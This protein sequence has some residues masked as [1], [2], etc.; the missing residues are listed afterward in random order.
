MNPTTLKQEVKKYWNQAA[1]GTEFID[2]KKYSREYFKAIEAFRY[3]IEPEIFA[4]A[5][6][7]RF[8]GKKVLEVGVGAG[9]DFVQW[10]RAGAIAYG[11]DLTE[12]A[13]NHVNHRLTINNLKAAEVTIGDAENLPY[14]N[15]SFDLVYS[16]GVIHH[17]PD[18]FKSLEELVRVT[19]PGGTIKLMIYNRSSLYAFYQYLRHALLRGKPF[20]SFRNVLYYHQESLGTQ[21]FTFKEAQKMIAQLPVTVNLMQAPITNHDL[22]YQKSK[23]F[24]WIAYICACLGG[25]KKRGWFMMIELEKKKLSQQVQ[26]K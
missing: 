19:K 11:V 3:S 8:H 6:F 21:A 17:S 23:P 18:T 25:W 7:S 1:C 2:Q 9:T 16:W 15:N 26:E 12:E 24:Q 10:V 13:I 20:K 5:Q 4:F 14:E 22:L